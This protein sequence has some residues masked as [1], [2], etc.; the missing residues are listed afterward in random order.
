MSQTADVSSVIQRFRAIQFHSFFEISQ[1]CLLGGKATAEVP[2]RGYYAVQDSHKKILFNLLHY[3]TKLDG[4]RISRI[5]SDSGYGNDI[6]G[7]EL[8]LIAIRGIGKWSHGA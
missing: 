3:N 6:T 4:S 2:C 5:Q 1:W 7:G 8:S